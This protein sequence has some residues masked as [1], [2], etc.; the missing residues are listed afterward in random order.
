MAVRF[1]PAR[2]E[3]IGQPSPLVDNVMQTFSTGSGGNTGAGQFSVAASGALIYAAGGIL[4]DTQ[5][6]LVWVDQRGVEQPVMPLKMPFFAPRLSPDGQ[7]ITYHALGRECQ[8]YVYDLN[9]GTNSRLTAEGRAAMPI[10]TPDGKRI[11]F[12]WQKSVV[13]NLFSQR[14]DGSSPMERLTTSE[15]EQRPGSWSSGGQT[16]ALVEGYGDTGQKILLLEARSGRVRPFLNSQF[17]ERFPE[18]SPDGRWIA[19]SSDESNRWEVYVVDYPDRSKKVQVSSQ[20][21]SE[22]L[23][24]KNG[25]QL[26]YRGQDQ[27][28]VVDVRTDGGFATSKPRLLIE[29]PGYSPASAIR[30]YDLSQDGQRFL[31]VKVEQRKPTP[32]TEMILVQNWFEELKQKLPAGK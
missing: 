9:T 19:Y 30:G 3:V 12:G 16:L 31:M 11:V 18:F 7:R 4:P 8:V 10:W 24:S 5:D 27:V 15:H 14:Y 23:W 17:D 26:F 1:D 25:K 29:R 2:L 13:G 20:G 32:V 22:P 6:S 28:W 21:G